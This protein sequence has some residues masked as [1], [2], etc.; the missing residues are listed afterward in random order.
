MIVQALDDIT[1]IYHRPSG[2]TH[3]VVSPVPEI[4]AAMGPDALSIDE[5]LSTLSGAFEI[6]DPVEAL[7][8][9]AAHLDEMAAIG[10][11]RPV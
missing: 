10:L 11:V 8:I 9:I 7:P 1:L 6:G 2:Q 5:V 4:L 3:M